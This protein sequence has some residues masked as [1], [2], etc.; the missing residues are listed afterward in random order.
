MAS[1]KLAM[2]TQG[3]GRLVFKTGYFTMDAASTSQTQAWANNPGIW[4]LILRQRYAYRKNGQTEVG[5][6]A[7]SL[8]DYDTGLSATLFARGWDVA[9]ETNG[10]YTSDTSA[11]MANEMVFLG[12]TGGN[13]METIHTSKVLVPAQNIIVVDQSGADMS[14]SIQQIS[15]VESPNAQDILSLL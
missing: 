6:L 14:A 7:C 2:Q 4:R 13:W 1:F 10:G 15:W 12:L 3:P 5:Y 9:T 8:K 11:N